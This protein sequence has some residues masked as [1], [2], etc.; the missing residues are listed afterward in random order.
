MR[1]ELLDYHLEDIQ[2]GERTLLSGG[3]LFLNPADVQNE[4]KDLAR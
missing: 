4:I 1:L 2:W 3:T